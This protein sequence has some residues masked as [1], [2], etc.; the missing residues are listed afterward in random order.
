MKIK[1]K[2]KIKNPFLCFGRLH[3]SEDH[4]LRDI[5]LSCKKLMKQCLSTFKIHRF[6]VPKIARVFMGSITNSNQTLLTPQP[7]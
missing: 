4:L 7:L 6:M 3:Q 2:L 1:I 5:E